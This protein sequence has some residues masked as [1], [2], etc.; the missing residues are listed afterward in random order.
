MEEGLARGHG[1]HREEDLS[2][3]HRGTEEEDSPRSFTE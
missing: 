3:R 2:Q 1:G